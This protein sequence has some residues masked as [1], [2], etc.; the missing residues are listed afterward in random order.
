[1]NELDITGARCVRP[2]RTQGFWQRQFDDAPTPAQRRFD[3]VFGIVMPI[4]CF[5]FDPI[6][7]RNEFEYRGGGLYSEYQL[8]AYT[9]GALEMVALCA[10]FL[11][12]GR[13]GRRPAA[14][15]GMLLAG[16]LFSFFIGL[17]ILPYSIVGLL[18][19]LIGALGFVPFLTAFVYLRNGWRA[20]GTMG[21]A[22]K[23]SPGLAAIALACGF[24]FALGVPAVA[25]VSVE[26]EI[27]AALE[28]VREGRPL[29]PERLSALRAAA[30]VSGSA[31][32][33]ELVWEYHGEPD[34]VRR[35][36][37]ANAYAE[38]TVGGDIERRLAV[39]LD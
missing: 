7:F 6:V 38:I 20:A 4:L 25:H 31:A 27:S 21:R 35:A 14:L 3:V 5:V 24:F 16:A 32:Y 30:A 17:T 2:R 15:A 33:D 39:L 10:W 18:F 9:F 13:A 37:L 34:R 1:M 26:S 22:G 8:Y 12:A 11:S 29:S 19:L 23:G 36:R 28:D